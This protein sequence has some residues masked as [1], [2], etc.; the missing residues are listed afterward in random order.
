MV[1]HSASLH[2]GH[3]KPHGVLIRLVRDSRVS[4]GENR[5]ETIFIMITVSRS[6]LLLR[7]PPTV[8]GRRFT[9]PVFLLQ[10]A[11]TRQVSHVGNT[12]VFRSKDTTRRKRIFRVFLYHFSLKNCTWLKEGST[13]KI[14][15]LFHLSLLAGQTRCYKSLSKEVFF[16]FFKRPRTLKNQL[17]LLFHKLSTSLLD[18]A[19]TWRI[20]LLMAPKYHWSHEEVWTLMEG[21]NQLILIHPDI[22][23]FSTLQLQKRRSY[24]DE[25]DLVTFE[26]FLTLSVFEWQTQ[27]WL[28]WDFY[29]YT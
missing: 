12:S 13:E 20:D 24:F 16:F 22:Y 15:F 17:I 14:H 1:F 18:S 26:G 21:K 8:A 9:R 2:P 5:A 23:Y 28:Q 29:T 11:F 4:G 3:Q 19:V 6:P 7:G 25:T 10:S 27:N